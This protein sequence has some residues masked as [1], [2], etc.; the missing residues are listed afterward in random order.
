M[1]AQTQTQAQTQAQMQTQT[2]PQAQTHA[3]CLYCTSF[4]AGDKNGNRANGKGAAVLVTLHHNKYGLVMGGG[5]ERFGENAN[6]YNLAAGKVENC[7]GGC[8]VGTAMRELSEEYGYTYGQFMMWWRGEF[9]VHSGTV[10]LIVNLP[11]GT[12]SMACVQYMQAQIADPKAPDCRKEMSDFTW[13]RMDTGVCADGS[14]KQLS[15]FA[16]AARRRM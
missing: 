11:A 1:Q 7:D 9:I 13:F 4:R 10:V 5:K 6:T 3:C 16:D 14:K 12:R 15:K 2:Q 8:M